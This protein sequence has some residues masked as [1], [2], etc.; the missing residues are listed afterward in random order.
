MFGIKRGTTKNSFG[1]LSC[2]YDEHIRPGINKNIPFPVTNLAHVILGKLNNGIFKTKDQYGHGTPLINVWDLY[3]SETINIDSLDRVAV[4]E[5]EL[6]RFN[7][8]SND[9]FYCRSSLKPEGIAWSCLIE[10]LSEPTVYECHL[11]KATPNTSVVDPSYLNYFSRSAY[12]RNYLLSKS[13][14][15]TMATIDQN[16]LASLPVILPQLKMQIKLVDSLTA[17]KK[18]RDKKQFLAEELLNGLDAFILDKLNI[19]KPVKAHINFF[20]HKKA[21]IF[22]SRFDAHFHSPYFQKIFNAIQN[23]R[24]KKI[25]LSN[26]LED[27]SGGATPKKGDTELYTFE[28]IKFL[29]ILNVKP[30]SI[31]LADVKYIQQH[32]HDGELKRS[33]LEENDVVMTIT[34]RVGTAATIAKEILP[35]NINQHLVRLRLKNNSCLPKYLAAYLNTSVG[36]AMTNKGASGG[37][38]IAVDYQWIASL[39]IPIPPLKIQQQIIDEIVRLQDEYKRLVNEATTEWNNAKQWFEE[40]LL[41]KDNE[42]KL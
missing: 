15:T 32:V 14:V 30:N 41:G 20:A 29:R 12:A 36:N 16:T 31:D 10:E 37:T 24:F 40:Q 19:L 26:L 33:Q 1:S 38:R 5:N 25:S 35:A 2:F 22:N 13:V 7:V 3:R 9:I 17:S 28:G 42:S 6:K 21:Q 34:G 39:P 8:A 11:I 27:L 4:N 23:S 18:I